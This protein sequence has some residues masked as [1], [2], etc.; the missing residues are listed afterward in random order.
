MFLK[1]FSILLTEDFLE[2]VLNKQEYR[3]D[4]GKL[5]D[6]KIIKFNLFN[7]IIIHIIHIGFQCTFLISSLPICTYVFSLFQMYFL[8][9]H[10]YIYIF[11]IS[12]YLSG[13]LFLLY[14]SYQ[15]FKLL[16][17]LNSNPVF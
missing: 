11:S 8:L 1:R 12:F 14:R 16:L 10:I 4:Y 13:M 5:Y 17:D 6:P 3:F 2:N 7:L 9:S 15:K